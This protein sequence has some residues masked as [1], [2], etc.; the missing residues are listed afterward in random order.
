M[1]RLLR[2]VGVVGFVF[3]TLGLIALLVG[4]GYV[5]YLQYQKRQQGKQF[6]S[7]DASLDVAINDP[8]DPAA[9][10]PSPT[11]SVPLSLSLSDSLT[12]CAGAGT[13]ADFNYADIDSVIS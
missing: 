13:S 3:L 5:G 4:L 6:P 11:L 7:L 1:N 10:P 8:G 12:A 2:H 9:F